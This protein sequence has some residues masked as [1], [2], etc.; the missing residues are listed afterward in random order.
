MN[1][2]N[3]DD[4]FDFT[5]ASLEGCID[6]EGKRN[7]DFIQCDNPDRAG[8][9]LVRRSGKLVMVPDDML[10]SEETKGI[11]YGKLY[12]CDCQ[13]CENFKG[14]RKDP[15]RKA[16]TLRSGQARTFEGMHGEG[17]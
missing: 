13:A 8:Y 1:A 5:Q 11:E 12:K 16:G 2:M 7:Y 3:D 10:T 17:R 14:L 4:V 9:V 6:K 15:V